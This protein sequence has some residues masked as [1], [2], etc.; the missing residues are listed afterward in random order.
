MEDELPPGGSTAIELNGESAIVAVSKL[1][2]RLMNRDVLFIEQ[3]RVGD[4]G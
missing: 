4:S 1:A 3:V 2:D